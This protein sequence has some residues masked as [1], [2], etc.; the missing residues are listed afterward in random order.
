MVE[1]QW[2][3]S[4]SGPPR[5]LG[6]KFVYSAQVIVFLRVR[7]PV[8]PW[9]LTVFEPAL[10]GPEFER[11]VAVRVLRMRELHDA[12]VIGAHPHIRAAVLAVGGQ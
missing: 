2:F 10:G 9:M 6:P 4:K 11:G 1:L 3:R 7:A 8:H 5:P 12:L